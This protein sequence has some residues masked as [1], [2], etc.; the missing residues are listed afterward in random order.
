MEINLDENVMRNSKRHDLRL[1]LD[2]HVLTMFFMEG[3][4]VLTEFV[5]FNMGKNIKKRKPWDL[6][7]CLE[8]SGARDDDV[9]VIINNKSLEMDVEMYNLRKSQVKERV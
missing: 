9:N 5:N 6:K 7:I 4:Y 2:G 8:K 3:R 1:I